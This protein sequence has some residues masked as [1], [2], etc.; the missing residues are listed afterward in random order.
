MKR[1]IKRYLD[2]IRNNHCPLCGGK[3]SFWRKIG[4]LDWRYLHKCPHCEKHLTVKYSRLLW[5]ITLLS[6]PAALIS[7]FLEYSPRII[8]MAVLIL[9]ALEIVVLLPFLPIV[10]D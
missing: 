2:G 5:F 7:Y 3:I 8:A 10:D 9:W 6:V 1:L 4:F